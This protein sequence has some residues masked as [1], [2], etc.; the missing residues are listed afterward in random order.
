MIR[1]TRMLTFFLI[2]LFFLCPTK[3]VAAQDLRKLDHYLKEVY[4]NHIIPGFSVVVVNERGLVYKKGFGK[5]RLDW[6]TPFTGQ[7]VNAIGSLTKSMT[8]MAIM[9]LVEQGDLELDTPVV[10]YLPWFRTANK[11]MSDKVTVRML[12]NNT[13]GL[14]ASPEPSYDLSDNALAAL[15]RNLRSTFITRE[16]GTVYEY[17]NL[18]FSIAGYVISQ[19]SGLPY[20]EYLDKQLFGPLAMKSTSTDP[21]KFGALGALEGHYQG[22]YQATPA[23]REKQFESGEYI[24]AGSFTRSTAQDL[25]NYLMA[26]LNKG[27]F[28]NARLL[29][30]ESIAEMWSP[31]SSFPGLMEDEGGDGKPIQYGLGWMISE[32]EGR[33]IVHH[34]GSTGKMSSMTM[35]DLTNNRAATLLANIDLTF[36]DQYQYPTIFNLVNNIL[37]IVSGEPIT[38]FGRPTISDPSLNDFDLGAAHME[39]Y[40]GEFVQIKGGDFWVYFGLSLNIKRGDK[41]LE[42]MMTRGKNTINHFELDFATPSLAIGRNMGIPQRV[43]FKLTPDG[44]VKGL[45]CGGM[46]YIRENKLRLE[47]YKKVEP[48]PHLGF[49]LPKDWSLQKLPDGFMA[50]DPNDSSTRLRGFVKGSR[51]KVENAIAKVSKRTSNESPWFS[52]REG[53]YV[54]K[55]QSS[56]RLGSHGEEVHTLFYNEMN[57][58][59]IHFEITSKKENHTLIL[60]QVISPLLNS[61]RFNG[62]NQ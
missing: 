44:K 16:P 4:D 42:A 53:Q 43:Q 2:G 41:G 1:K 6:T 10:H 56:V 17:N 40:V 15:T 13:S 57:N 62:G 26:L 18:G 14:Q 9:Q 50:N 29:S 49:L 39:K 21:E 35:I 19:V 46:E 55:H 5:E 38:E 52:I 45:F 7:T 48:G 25:G 11:D 36:I 60:Q 24:P 32:I 34:G 58:I 30:E 20:K 31:N 61:L 51:K 47:R 3:P 28:G 22:I 27:K 12:I 33:K 54:W 37:H 23:L 59:P 8:A